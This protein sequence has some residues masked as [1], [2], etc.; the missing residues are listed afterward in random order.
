MK[1]IILALILLFST[2]AF[3]EDAK[4]MPFDQLPPLHQALQRDFSKWL[5]QEEVFG[6]LNGD[7]I[8][9][10]AVMIVL[11]GADPESEDKAALAVMFGVDKAGKEF[12]LHAQ[13]GGITCFDCGG[14]KGPT[15]GSPLGHLA[16]TDKGI[17]TINYLGGSRWMWDI[18]NKWR[19]DKGYN[20]MVLIGTTNVT[21]DTLSENGAEEE[22]LDINYST[23]KAEK[24]TKKGKKTC[25]VPKDQQ[26][27]EISGF[28]Y[29]GKFQTDMEA[30]EKACS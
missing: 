15:D 8:K 9:D 27:Q 23:L 30:V 5:V 24:T 6:D 20:R 4:R 11:E 18:M 19:Y 16:I 7:G 25:D 17:L 21:V 26:N 29:L 2:P 13:S 12:K 1:H 14:A 28:D 10:A 22:K 3:A